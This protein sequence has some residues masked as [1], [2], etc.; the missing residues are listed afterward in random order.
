MLLLKIALAPFVL[1]AAVFLAMITHISGLTL[2]H[3][4]AWQ[5]TTATV[6]NS[7]TLCE[8]TYQ[9][10]DAVLRAV[11]ARGPCETMGNVTLP[12]GGTTPRTLM[13]VFGAL[14]YD[15]DGVGQKW[16]GKLAD[17]G[18]YNVR[19]GDKLTLFYDPSSPQHI[20]SAQYKGWF[21]G[22]LIFGVSAGL[23]VFCTWLAWPRRRSPIDTGGKPNNKNSRPY[24]PPARAVN[25]RRQGFGRA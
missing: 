7:E 6:L 4:L 10:V 3:R 16:E 20:D 15:T 13:G 19:A 22:L 12:R 5:P 18:V 14:A 2:H 9:P 24:V 17:A 11:A 25:G 21:G 23:I 8:V 1:M